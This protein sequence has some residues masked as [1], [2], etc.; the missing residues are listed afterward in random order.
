MSPMER[1]EEDRY[2]QDIATLLVHLAPG[3]WEV[4]TLAY[5]AIGTSFERALLTGALAHP[6]FVGK[7][8]RD[9]AGALI[10]AEVLLPVSGI[11][12][13]LRRLRTEMHEDGRGTWTHLRLDVHCSRTKNPEELLWGVTYQYLD[14]FPRIDDAKLM[15]DVPASAFAEELRMFPRPLH[16]VP[17]WAA[18]RAEV[19]AA[20][21]TLDP[22][23]QARTPQDEARL[24]AA[25]PAGLEELFDWTRAR[26]AAI[27]PGREDRF[28]VG[29]LAEG[30]WS[31]LHHPPA[32]IAARYQDGRCT[33]L[34]AFTGPRE[35]VR[36][37]AAG[38]VADAEV[39]VDS[40]VL[41]SAGIAS[42]TVQRRGDIDAWLLTS[43]GGRLTHWSRG[44]VRPSGAEAEQ[45]RYVDLQVV[46]NRPGGYFVLPAG[47]PP[48]KGE[49]LSVHEVFEHFLDEV[50]PRAEVEAAPEPEEPARE[51]L[52]V[53]VELD[54]H[55]GTDRPFLFTIGTPFSQR[56]LYGTP[57]AYPYR[58]FRVAKE[59]EAFPG[60]FADAPI[61]PTGRTEP[62]PDGTGRGFY[63]V[64][65]ID[66][67][68]R[69]GHLVE[70]DAPG[71]EPIA[72]T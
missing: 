29:R 9:T 13:L 28:Q 53:G 68:L 49:F 50:L 70:I 23:Q 10:P 57:D 16:S 43:K 5:Q 35:A 6:R 37:A 46:N 25:L 33:Q 67:L 15:G 64:H 24:V 45:H 31:V 3:A 61:F 2:L 22:A 65:S 52:P 39:P 41:S 1:R 54:A 60:L 11:Y 34:R 38:V 55:G 56:G 17:G 63:L 36:Y 58:A 26:L 40:A 71:G 14:E 12:P 69:S 48:E 66:D 30:C 72:G 21:E 4:V 42:R 18:H 7:N 8:L 19:H 62:A 27:A 20:A 51:V 59:L 32:W 44:A 47:P